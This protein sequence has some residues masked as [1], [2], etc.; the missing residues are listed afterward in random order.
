MIITL[1]DVNNGLYT[2]EIKREVGQGA[3]TREFTKEGLEEYLEN[4][5][6]YCQHKGY[7]FIYR[8]NEL[9]VLKEN[10]TV[11][12]AAGDHEPTDNEMDYLFSQLPLSKK[13]FDFTLHKHSCEI[14]CNCNEDTLVYGF[15]FESPYPDEDIENRQLTVLLCSNCGKWSA[16]D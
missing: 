8:K 6:Q 9:Q 1:T 3:Y 4:A 7:E 14:P 16:C 13:D 5:K 10:F 15:K 11:V 2:V 12:Y